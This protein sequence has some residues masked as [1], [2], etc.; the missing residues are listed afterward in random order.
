MEQLLHSD[1]LVLLLLQ[2][3]QL[4]VNERVVVRD[5]HSVYVGG[6]RR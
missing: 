5:L 4:G 1:V 2:I 6:R 3:N